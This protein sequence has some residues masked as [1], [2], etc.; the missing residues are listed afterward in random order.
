MKVE[1]NPGRS[2]KGFSQACH[3]ICWKC[4]NFNPSVRTKNCPVQRMINMA[5]MSIKRDRWTQRKLPR[6]VSIKIFLLC[7]VRM[8]RNFR[9]HRVHWKAEGNKWCNFKDKKMQGCSRI[10][11]PL[12]PFLP[13]V[14]TAL[15]KATVAMRAA[16]KKHEWR[17][18]GYHHRNWYSL[19]PRCP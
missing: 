14:A 9:D 15:P 11:V 7:K 1:W 13:P 19:I 6:Q 16:T 10:D 18:Y 4:S 3:C 8:A 5:A 17:W 12:S 2:K